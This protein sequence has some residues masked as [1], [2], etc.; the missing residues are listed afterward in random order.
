MLYIYK[1]YKLLDFY[2]LPSDVFHNYKCDLSFLSFISFKSRLKTNDFTLQSS[3][4]CTLRFRLYFLHH[5]V[6]IFFTFTCIINI[7][8]RYITRS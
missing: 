1:I 8:V 3:V 2:I 7:T 5:S 6:F 4:M